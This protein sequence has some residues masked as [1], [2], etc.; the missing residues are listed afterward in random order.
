MKNSFA[1]FSKC[2]SPVVYDPVSFEESFTRRNAH[3]MPRKMD[4]IIAARTM[5]MIKP[6]ELSES[7][8]PFSAR[9]FPSSLPV[10][11]DSVVDNPLAVVFGF[12]VCSGGACV[13][14]FVG[15][16]AAALVVF[17]AIVMVAAVVAV[18]MEAAA[19]AVFWVVAACV[20]VGW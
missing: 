18:V 11:E 13:A 6:L 4:P 14:H 10:P 16:V 9:P 20:L 2:I 7:P 5:P 12:F 19:V 3:R 15:M 17:W 1:L 8:S